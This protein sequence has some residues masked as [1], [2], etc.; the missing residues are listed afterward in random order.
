MVEIITLYELAHT[1]TQPKTGVVSQCN[2]YL[3]VHDNACINVVL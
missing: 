1:L 3:C 2:V